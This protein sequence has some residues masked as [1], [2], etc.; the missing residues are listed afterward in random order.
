MAGP[1]KIGDLAGMFD[2]SLAVHPPLADDQLGGIPARRGVFLLSSEDDRPILLATAASIRARLR[3]RLDEPDEEKRRRSADLRTITRT[4]HWKLASGHFEMDW[5]YLEIARSIW[6]ET[7]PKL[8]SWRPAWFVH[9]RAEE[10]FPHFMRTRDVLASPGRYL[11]P[12]E[13]GRSAD[14]FVDTVLDAFD[15]CRD[16][17]CLRR[18]PHGQRCAYGQMGRCLCPCDGGISMEAYR[19]VMGGAADFA[20][21]R[22]IEHVQWLRGQM[23][24]ASAELKFERAAAVKARL[25]RLAELDGDSYR[26]VA[27]ADE[28]RFLLIQPSGSRRKVKV[29]LADRG[30]I[31]RARPL[32]WPLAGRQVAG[33]IRRMARLAAAGPGRRG[34]PADRWRM[35]LVA[36][37]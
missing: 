5:D 9:V 2:A 28:F 19:R 1:K 25:D 7:F 26:H 29:F 10:A 21:G 23:N 36:R 22:R 15:L 13:S 27:P 20:A 11:G 18:S 32:D 16:V 8:L 6:P 17:Q 35:G 3:S 24:A 14:R 4:V 33:T 37:A 34:D 31:V 30:T 12:F